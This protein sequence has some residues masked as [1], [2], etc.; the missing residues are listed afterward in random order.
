MDT[1]S[2]RQRLQ[3][4]DYPL[5]YISAGEMA[6]ILEPVVPEG[7]FLRVDSRR[8]IL[9]LAGTQTQLDGWLDMIATFDVDQ[10]EG[11]SVGVFPLKNASVDDVFAE[12]ELI[13]R[14]SDKPG[15]GQT[16]L[17]QA[18][19]VMPVK[20]LNSV[21]AVSPRRSYITL[22]QE[23]VSALDSIQETAVEATLHVYPVANGNAVP[24]GRFAGKYLRLCRR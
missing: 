23:W 12:L 1:Y 20:R 9:I 24:A 14:G 21:L 16:D 8:N 6:E 11:M 4:S 3:Q 18:V 13:L 19:K 17:S 15:K 10:L 22:V 7:A 5:Q 2:P